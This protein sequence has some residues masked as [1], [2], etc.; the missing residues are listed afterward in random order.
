MRMRNEEKFKQ[1]LN[2]KLGEENFPFDESNWAGAEALL[3]ADKKG[4]RGIYYLIPV[5]LI[6]GGAATY[7]LWPQGNADLLKAKPLDVSQTLNEVMAER[8]NAKA[9]VPLENNGEMIKTAQGT[10]ASI[11]EVQKLVANS[12]ILKNPAIVK[13]IQ[14]KVV[15]KP[16]QE[17]VVMENAVDNV[18]NQTDASL[19]NEDNVLPPSSNG[20][21]V[22]EN[23][24]PV[25]PTVREQIVPTGVSTPTVNN[26]KQESNHIPE[27]VDTKSELIVPAIVFSTA[28]TSKNEMPIADL[29]AMEPMIAPTNVRNNKTEIN[30]NSIVKEII[31][32]TNTASLQ[33]KAEANKVIENK[34]APA[35]PDTSKKLVLATEPITATVLPIPSLFLFLE[36]GSAYNLGYQ[37]LG[38]IDGRGFNPLFGLQLMS[39]INKN[40]SF[41][42]GLQYQSVGH[43]NYS[44][45]ISKVTRYGLG[46][47][48]YVTIIT[49]STAH[50]LYLP[51]RVNYQMKEKHIF[52]LGC[53]IGYLMN[54]SSKVETYNEHFNYVDN[55]KTYS[56]GGY[57]EGFAMFETQLA[58]AY[59]GKLY[60]NFWLRSELYVGLTDMKNN[61]FFGSNVF[62]RNSGIKVSLMYQLFKK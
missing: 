19:K 3:D 61:T 45:H 21:Q 43:L 29:Q 16:K 42:F 52:S 54:V 53:N 60:R 57:T 13:P 62:E 36:L 28:V 56:T 14:V 24:L 48:S 50:Y 31:P 6:L 40:Y 17:T 5:L 1:A 27:K 38:S 2:S 58:L 10:K 7:W 35:S 23:E 12:V 44:R 51:L 34:L 11:P 33:V 18:I 4:R 26:T 39:V 30:A 46:E 32:T 49:P 15:S 55:Y 9:N 20:P 41:S 59:Q 8:E 37:N 22:V 47:D 25:A